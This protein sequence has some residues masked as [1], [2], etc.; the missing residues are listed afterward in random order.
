[1]SD[2][3]PTRIE[4]I[5]TRKTGS[6][7]PPDA[8]VVFKITADRRAY[9]KEHLVLMMIGAAGMYW[10]LWAIGNPHPWTGIV[11]AVFA[12][13][14]RWI[15]VASEAMGVVWNVTKTH[16]S[17]PSERKIPLASI[18]KT[19]TLFS[20]VQVITHNGDKYMLKYLANTDATVTAIL[21]ARDRVLT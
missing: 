9:N 13:F 14:V 7:H 3:E 1:M 10:L 12:I 15:Y 17:G 2:I 4:E 11:G 20:A 18:K 8:D 6:N 16:L 21:K 19:R 5:V